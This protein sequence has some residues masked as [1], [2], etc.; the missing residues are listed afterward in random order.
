[1]LWLSAVV[2]MAECCGCCDRMWW[3]LWQ[4]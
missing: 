2:A 1:M 3:L 4:G